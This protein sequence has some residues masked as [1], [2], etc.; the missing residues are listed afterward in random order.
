M[1]QNQTANSKNELIEKLRKINSL[2]EEIEEIGSRIEKQNFKDYFTK[3]LKKSKK[4]RPVAPS[5]P[6]IRPIQ[7]SNPASGKII[8]YLLGVLSFVPFVILAFI[9]LFSDFVLH[10]I[11]Y[12]L[13]VIASIGTFFW[14]TIRSFPKFIEE[15]EK[16]LDII[17]ANA[18][19][20][21][22]NHDY[23]KSMAEYNLLK[24]QYDLEK[25]EYDLW[26]DSF[27]EAKKAEYETTHSEIEAKHNELI[28]EL[29]QYETIL[30]PKY[31]SIAKEISDALEDGRAEILSEALNLVLAD[32]QNE[33]IL[34]EQRQHNMNMLSA[35]LIA[36]Q[37]MEERMREIT[38][39]QKEEV[40]AERQRRFEAE[41]RA[42]DAERKSRQ[43]K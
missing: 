34:A 14:I 11:P 40:E 6:T 12:A 42:R 36:N 25:S 20:R 7:K 23:D 15:I 32:K 30:S 28:N 37:Q 4:K 29:K 17:K 8:I 5:K 27:C 22:A 1:E 38:Y 16:K 18:K 13:M 3:A 19:I 31:H 41:Q 24:K 10:E 33:R 35:Q 9:F 21:K 43:S 26:Y 2:Y 39:M